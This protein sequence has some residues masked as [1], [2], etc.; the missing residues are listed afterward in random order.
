VFTPGAGIRNP[1]AS[2]QEAKAGKK[3]G[4]ALTPMVATEKGTLK[5]S[6]RQWGKS[7]GA[8]END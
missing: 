3:K 1:H 4:K 2:D 5:G 8:S 6:T 7:P